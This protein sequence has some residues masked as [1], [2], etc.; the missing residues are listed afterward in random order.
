MA[1]K[2]R[3]FVLIPSELASRFAHAAPSVHQSAGKNIQHGMSD[4]IV[5]KALSDAEKFLHYTQD[6]QNYLVQKQ[7][8]ERPVKLGIQDDGGDGVDQDDSGKPAAALRAALNS[9]HLKRQ[10]ASELLGIL[11]MIPELGWNN[12]GE[13]SV[14]GQIIPGSSLVALVNDVITFAPST[15][16]VGRDQ[17]AQIIRNRVPAGLVQERTGVYR[18]RAE[19]NVGQ[20]INLDGD[21]NIQIPQQ[22]INA[23]GPSG[24]NIRP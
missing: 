16:P 23:P 15:Y 19:P 6:Q 7:Y 8:M 21:E 5:N 4:V 13:I 20:L 11:N 17:F 9:F 1:N 22:N 14:H 10:P 2:V 18:P 12:R 24:L 3:K